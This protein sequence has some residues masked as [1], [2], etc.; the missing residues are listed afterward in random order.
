MGFSKTTQLLA[1]SLMGELKRSNQDERLI[2]FSDSRQDAAK[3]ALDLEG[4]ITMTQEES[5]LFDH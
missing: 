5:W 2:S 3:A 1:S 4:G